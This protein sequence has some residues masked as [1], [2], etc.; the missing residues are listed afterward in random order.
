MARLVGAV[1][2]GALVVIVVRAAPA[3]ADAAGPSD[4]DTEVVSV[5]PADSQL[6]WTLLG[7]DS[8]VQL[9]VPSGVSAEVIGYHGEPYLLFAADGTVRRNRLAPTTYE[10]EDRFAAVSEPDPAVSADADPQW[11]QVGSDGR[12]AWHDHRAH[13]MVPA[14]PPGA[15]PGDVI[16]GGTI[17]VLINGASGSVTVESTWLAPAS[18]IPAL[19]GA[20][21]AVAIAAAAWVTGTTGRWSAVPLA[22]VPV[23]AAASVVAGA[24]FLS[25]PAEARISTL[26][27]ILPLL[28]TAAVAV[29]ARLGPTASGWAAAALGSAW[30]G[31]WAVGR[32]GA[33]DAAVLPTRLW[34][35]LDRA[36]TAAAMVAAALVG[37]WTVY[38]LVIGSPVAE[39]DATAPSKTPPATA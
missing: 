32:R 35:P 20:A 28:A 18:P 2:V 9:T 30:L 12:Y 3:G 4:F 23:A 6:V 13:W 21:I 34:W 15:S 11:E 37:A 7:G 5:D 38:H 27:L 29:A 33:L 1:L 39:S 24:E 25:M 14:P 31:A 22:A 10:N 16:M 8:F 26:V 17:P 19:V 36:V